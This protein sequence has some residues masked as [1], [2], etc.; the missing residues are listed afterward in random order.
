MKQKKIYLLIIAVVLIAG[1]TFLLLRGLSDEDS[2]IKD[3]RGVYIKH[4]NPSL[5]PLY[6]SEQEKTILCANNLYQQNKSIINFSSQCLGICS[7]YAVDIVHIPRSE[8]D[9]LPEN[10]CEAFRNGQV[11]HFI[12][13]D[14]DGEIVKII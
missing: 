1:G 14:K 10:Q 13:L 2:W 8:E 6:V 12:E 9:N 7:D 4:G 11:T 5:K 3:S